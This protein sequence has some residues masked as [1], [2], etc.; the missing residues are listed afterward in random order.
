MAHAFSWHSS[1]TEFVQLRT[2]F[3]QVLDPELAGTF[4]CSS[5]PTHSAA[6]AGPTP[7]FG[8]LSEVGGS[9]TAPRLEPEAPGTCW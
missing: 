8:A 1:H 7:S 4:P 6:T 3:S 9:A 5:T 2:G